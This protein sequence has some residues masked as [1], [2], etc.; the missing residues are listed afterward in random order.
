VEAG[1]LFENN[2]SVEEE[3]PAYDACHGDDFSDQ[4]INV[5]VDEEHYGYV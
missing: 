2:K 4:R 5:I 1:S 3:I